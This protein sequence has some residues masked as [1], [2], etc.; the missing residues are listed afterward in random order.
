MIF[1]IR[2]VYIFKDIRILVFVYLKF[3]IIFAKEKLKKY[4]Y[5][6]S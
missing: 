5:D 3:F 1:L 4:Q 2:I 6:N